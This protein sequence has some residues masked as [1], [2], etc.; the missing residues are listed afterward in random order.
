MKKLLA[1]AVILTAFAASESFAQPTSTSN[2]TAQVSITVNTA[3]QLQKN[4]DLAF[5]T[6]VQGVTS[7]TVNPITGGA[8][9]ARFTMTSPVNQDITV[10]YTTTDLTSGTNTIGFSGAGTLSGNQNLAQGSSTT[11][12]N[13]STVTTTNGTYYFWAGGTATL[14]ANQAAGQY[15]GSF[16]L[17]VS[18]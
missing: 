12:T 2:A 13:N 9:A 6:V 10:Q 16:T 15:S 17:T 4:N 5:G 18:Y 3:V 8:S 1:I 11:V 14:A 7:A